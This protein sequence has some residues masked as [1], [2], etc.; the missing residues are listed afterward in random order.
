M[1]V[2]REAG[3]RCLFL[4]D[5]LFLQMSVLLAIVCPYAILTGIVAGGTTVMMLV[6]AYYVIFSFSN[7]GQ[8]FINEVSNLWIVRRFSRRYNQ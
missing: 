7:L 6:V 8:A 2:Q 1:E 5:S 4:V 3:A